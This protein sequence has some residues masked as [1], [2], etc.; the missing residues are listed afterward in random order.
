MAFDILIPD[1]CGLRK[2]WP[3]GHE[4]M[5]CFYSRKATASEGLR[6]LLMD[7]PRGNIWAI[8]WQPKKG[9]PSKEAKGISSSS[10][11]KIS[12]YTLVL[13]LIWLSWPGCVSS[14]CYHFL[15]TS[16][17]SEN[18][19]VVHSYKLKLK[20]SNSREKNGRI[21]YKKISYLFGI[22]N[23]AWKLAVKVRL[24]LLYLLTSSRRT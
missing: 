14:N 3:M 24:N 5:Q 19:T 7:R 15:V 21:G 2:S 12:A 10:C 16:E 18:Q 8:A 4:N 22:P 9:H 6:Q 1:W 17:N 20:R 11:V 13:G 23:K